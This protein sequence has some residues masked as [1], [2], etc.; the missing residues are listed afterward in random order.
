MMPG[1][2]AGDSREA[3][4]ACVGMILLLVAAFPPVRRTVESSMTG[5]MLV[6]YAWLLVAGGLLTAGLPARWER[7]LQRWNEMGIAGLVGCA[8]T[9]AVLMV[10][11]VLDLAL[12]DMRVETLKVLALVVSGAAIRL[13]W[14]RAGVVVQL[15]FLGHVLPM[16]AVVGSLYQN[17]ATRVC[18]A[19]RLDDQQ[20]LGQLLVWIAVGV[21]TLWLLRL[22]PQCLHADSPNAV[23][24][25]A[26][27]RDTA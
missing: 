11:R 22:A 2:A 3:R 23:R 10:P 1:R 19:Y 25:A 6:Q 26:D 15:F 27:A 20:D 8:L 18:N 13:S 16:M 14:Q 24:P 4:Q 17:S 21:A 5:H 7:A 9:L 12:I